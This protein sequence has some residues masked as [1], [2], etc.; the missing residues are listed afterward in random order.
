MDMNIVD[1]EAPP[2]EKPEKTFAEMSKQQYA[3]IMSQAAHAEVG[4]KLATKLYPPGTIISGSPLSTKVAPTPTLPVLS[5]SV[6]QP[7]AVVQPP[8][9]LAAPVLPVS[10]PTMLGP[11]L[12]AF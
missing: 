4:T 11:A 10:I 5:A 12:P 9:P 1:E 7:A 6:N 3:L 2:M 8:M